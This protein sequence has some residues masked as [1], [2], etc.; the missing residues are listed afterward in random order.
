MIKEIFNLIAHQKWLI[1]FAL[2]ISLDAAAHRYFFALTEISLNEKSQH[3]E[4]IHEVSLHDLESA[5]SQVDKIDFSAEDP[6]YEKRLQQYIENEFSLL[7]KNI[8][9]PLVWVGVEFSK[10]HATFYQESIKSYFLN[11]LVVKNSLLVDTYPTQINTVNYQQGLIKGSL[12]FT[13]HE[14]TH[15]IKFTDLHL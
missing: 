7:Q 2:I 1:A 8:A 14:R 5:I 13:E 15:I 6:L 11:G 10:Y 3:I 4:V 9:I 12:T